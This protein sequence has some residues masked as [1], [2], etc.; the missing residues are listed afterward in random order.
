M[1]F[2]CWT[3]RGVQFVANNP[4]YVAKSEGGLVKIA[5]LGQILDSFAPSKQ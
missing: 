3:P 1:K 5:A 4:D 2:E